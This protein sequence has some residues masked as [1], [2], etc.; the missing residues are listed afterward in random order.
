MTQGNKEIGLMNKLNIAGLVAVGI[1]LG[2]AAHSTENLKFYGV[3]STGVEYQKLES[4][5][6][7]AQDR[8]R[9]DTGEWSGSRLGV[10]GS[11][12][13]TP[14]VTGIFKLE[15]GYDSTD[16]DQ[17]Q[18]GRL[19]G[20]HATVGVDFADVGTLE[21]GRATSAAKE[22]LTVID[23]FGASF[24]TSTLTSSFGDAFIRHDDVI[25]F[26]S[27][28]DRPFRFFGSYSFDL[29]VSSNS[30]NAKFE[31]QNKDRAVSVG[32]SYTMPSA[33]VGMTYS[34][35]MSNELNTGAGVLNNDTDITA[36]AIGGTINVGAV[37]VH[38]MIGQ[39][40]NGLVGF[41]STIEN[42]AG[43]NN[44]NAGGLNFIDGLTATASMVGV[45]ADVAGGTLRVGY[46]QSE[47]DEFQGATGIGK[48]K[49]TSVAYTRN[50]SEQL[51]IYAYMS[52]ASNLNMIS[53]TK[54]KMIGSGI[55]F[56]F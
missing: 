48:Q 45:T 54:S 26:S 40:K 50:I 33:M 29:G 16:G 18:G 34:K 5:G 13:V 6:Q 31:T 3:V 12:V 47:M 39:Q 4:T 8:F 49:I 20:R 9:M 19:F 30:E 43:G 35:Y 36:A 23:P 51:G 11:Y 52:N 1:G 56:S 55:R 42:I 25:K 21:L 2:T 37:K 53:G 14:N 44:A 41:T 27:D 38:A 24:G 7:A 17:S 28:E 10:A 22:V 46:Q 32:A 15:L